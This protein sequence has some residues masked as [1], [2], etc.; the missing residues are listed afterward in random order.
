MEG[1]D[2]ERI[3]NCKRWKK[4][5][6]KRTASERIFFLRIISLLI[7]IDLNQRA[8]CTQPRARLLPFLVKEFIVSR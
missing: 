1:A 3:G 4:R 6:T 2:G 7:L 8:C 5:S